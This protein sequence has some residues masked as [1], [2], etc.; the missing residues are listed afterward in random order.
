MPRW[1]ENDEFR[2]FLAAFGKLLALRKALELTERE[3]LQFILVA[4]AGL[5]GEVVRILNEV[6]ELA[7]RVSAESVSLA[8][9]DYVAKV[10]A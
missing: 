2:R 3:V 10:P 7:S 1:R 5:A 6:A 4:S 8:H 9:L